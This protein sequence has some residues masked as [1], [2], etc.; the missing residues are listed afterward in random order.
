ME[1]KER[2][3]KM[4]EIRDGIYWTGKVDDRKVPFHR[5]ILEKGTSYNS[6]LIKDEKNVLIDTVDFMFGKEFTDRLGSEFDLL[7]LDYIVINHTEPD[8]SGALG[9]V[10]RKAKNATILCTE[11]AIPELMEMYKL[12]IE[13]FR[14]VKDNETLSIG[15]RTLRFLHTPYLHTEE[16]MVTYLEEEGILFT[17]DIFSTHVADTRLLASEL[18]AGE[19]IDP[20][21]TGYYSLIMDPHR[22]YVKPMLDKIDGL[23]ISMIA[24]SHGYILDKE[25]GRYIG[26]YRESSEKVKDVRTVILYNSMGGN[27]KRLARLLGEELEKT[28]ISAEVIDA[29]VRPKEE[30]L[31]KVADADGILVGASTKYADISGNLEGILAELKDMDLEGKVAG[32]F[33]SYGWS[34]EAA[35]VVQD[36]LKEAGMKVL[37][38][39]E[40]VRTTGMDDV[41]F[42]LRV[43]FKPEDSIDAVRAAAAYFADKVRY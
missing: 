35:H 24:T 4:R 31:A 20:D 42:P 7:K 3:M 21:F 6:Y 27:T 16:T 30:I 5:L 10:A 37:T 18:E 9:S 33:G 36:Y 2:M 32:A 43:R 19:S 40:A 11:I 41:A 28:G 29:N 26:L 38:T 1:R 15:K 17:C 39:E 8:H 34:G 14:A 23:E 13:R 25:P 12:G 22:R